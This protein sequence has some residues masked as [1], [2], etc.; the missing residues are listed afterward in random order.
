VEATN[1]VHIRWPQRQVIAASVA[2]LAG[3]VL[4]VAALLANPAIAL[5][6]VPFW[7]ICLFAAGA[8]ARASYATGD[9]AL[10]TGWRLVALAMLLT[11]LAS[12]PQSLALDARLSEAGLPRPGLAIVYLAYVA[13]G[14]AFYFLSHASRRGLIRIGLDLALITV[15]GMTIYAIVL[16][17][18]FDASLTASAFHNPRLYLPFVDAAFAM[19]LLLGLS[20]NL[21]GPRIRRGIPWAIAGFAALGTAH[22]W[23]A[24]A[25]FTDIPAPPAALVIPYIAG[26]ALVG[27]AALRFRSP[28]PERSHA[29]RWG[30]RQRTRSEG[31]WWHV[32][33]AITPYTVSMIGA[34]LLLLYVGDRDQSP[35]TRLLSLLVALLIV[36]IGGARQVLNYRDSH[37]LYGRLDSA[38]RDLERQVTE[39]TAELRRRNADLEAIHQVALMSDR[40]LD[41]RSAL[42]DVAHQLGA[43]ID[44]DYCRISAYDTL[45][46]AYE[47]L[48]EYRRT[49]DAVAPPADLLPRLP[50]FRAALRQRETL[51][52]TTDE[53]PLGLRERVVLDAAEIGATLIVPLATPE[54]LV[55]YIEAFRHADQSFTR[56]EVFV[57]ES[58]GAHVSLAIENAAAY[59]RARFAADHDRVTGLLNH[60]ALQERLTLEFE[61]CRLAGLPMSVAMI[62]LNTFKEFNDRFGHQ[63]G[64]K[65]LKAI[66]QAIAAAAPSGAS[67][68]R[69]GGDEFTLLMPG[70]E[71]AQAGVVIDAIH[72]QVRRFNAAHDHGGLEIGLSAGIATYPTDAQSPSALVDRADQLMYREKWSLKGYLDRRQAGALTEAQLL[73]D[74]DPHLSIPG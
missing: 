57:A 44:S 25:S 32:G 29:E 37:E 65:V 34:G 74:G 69:Y 31:V 24:T 15:G 8:A 14:A 68:S 20:N 22:G 49:P 16:R 10:R 56:D 3:A 67:V 13:A 51:C 5:P 9:P 35:S 58:I 70:Y 55:G 53:I 72:E 60:R 33:L 46:D 38:R 17:R 11:L 39:Q 41:V 54:R 73:A 64:D 63:T 19:I 62:D 48:G 66:G 71:R 43:T 42:D 27:V 18:V 1:C 21:T 28:L 26:I 61:R 30:A 47:A 7:A 40:T 59:E 52:L 12:V 4:F 2:G 45:T 23:R 50:E 36:A 6:F